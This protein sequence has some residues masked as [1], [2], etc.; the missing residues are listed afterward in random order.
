MKFVQKGQL[1]ILESTS[2][3]G[4]TEEEIVNKIKDKKNIGKDIFVCYSPEREDPGNK[5][6]KSTN[7]PKVTPVS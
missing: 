2:Y 4:T 1:I 5:I 6:F 3:P 7:V